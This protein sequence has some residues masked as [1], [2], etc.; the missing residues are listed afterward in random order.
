MK[1][2]IASGLLL[3]TLVAQLCAPLYA[4]A[5]TKSEMQLI[6]ISVLTCPDAIYFKTIAV[7]TLVDEKATSTRV[8]LSQPSVGVYSAVISLSPGHYSLGVEDGFCEGGTRVTAEVFST[9]EAT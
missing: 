5:E 7:A 1:Q 2:R 8:S 9:R 3:S 4:T 6:R